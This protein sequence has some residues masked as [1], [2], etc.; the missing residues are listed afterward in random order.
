MFIIEFYVW[1]LIRF[2]MFSV[3]FNSQSQRK[4][5]EYYLAFLI[6]VLPV[7]KHMPFLNAYVQLRTQKN[8]PLTTIWS[9]LN[10]DHT[11]TY[12]L[13]VRY[14][15]IFQLLL[16]LASRLFPSGFLLNSCFWSHPCGYFLCRETRVEYGFWP[17][18]KNT[19]ISAAICCA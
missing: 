11:K 7:E 2:I 16:G 10:P 8:L 19:V 12:V 9:Q 6:G 17:C 14:N 3:Y 5:V 18:E 13:Q 15:I 1:K 4:N